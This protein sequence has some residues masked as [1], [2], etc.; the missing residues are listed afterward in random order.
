MWAGW[1]GRFLP[2]RLCGGLEL[3]LSLSENWEESE[4]LLVGFRPE[5]EL[6][7]VVVVLG[8]RRSIDDVDVQE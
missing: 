3:S 2:R 8:W 5:S 6:V 4:I 7:V 1:K